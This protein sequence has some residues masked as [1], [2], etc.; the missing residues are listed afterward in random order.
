ML[1]RSVEA[2]RKSA[3]IRSIR[4]EAKFVCFPGS[5]IQHASSMYR[6]A[7]VLSAC[8]RCWHRL[9]GV[10]PMGPG[11]GHRAWMDLMIMT[12]LLGMATMDRGLHGRLRLDTPG[13][14][15]AVQL[16]RVSLYNY[17]TLPWLYYP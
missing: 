11:Y 12:E 6:A 8:V 17:I 7:L 3:E 10:A 16:S 9:H 4:A 2:R 15:W 14:P 1:R 13:H 5:Y